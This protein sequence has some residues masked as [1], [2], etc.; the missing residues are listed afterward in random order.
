MGAK[1]KKFL[2]ARNSRAPPA[3]LL[4]GKHSHMKNTLLRV[5]L[6]ATLLGATV[7]AVQTQS[8]RAFAEEKSEFRSISQADLQ[9]AINAKS[10]TIF[11]ANGDDSYKEGRIPT[12]LNF[13]K[14]QNN[15]KSVL[16]KNKNA[17]VVAY[18]GNP[19]CGAYKQAAQAAKKLGYTNVAHFSPGIAG[20]RASGAKQDKG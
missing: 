17:L 11:D 4:A 9:K 15:L 3:S 12:A 16:P 20:W 18:C 2:S 5:A 1:G 6:G 19:H 8:P 14:V 7:L 10:V 13:Y